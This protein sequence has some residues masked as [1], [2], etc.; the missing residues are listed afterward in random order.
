MTPYAPLGLEQIPLTDEAPWQGDP[1]TPIPDIAALEIH[2][3]LYCYVYQGHIYNTED[4]PYINIIASEDFVACSGFIMRNM[5]SGIDTLAHCWPGVT[6]F[7]LEEVLDRTDATD[8]PHEA[9]AVYGGVSAP[10]GLEWGYANNRWKNINTRAV[11]V[12][13][14]LNWWTAVFNRAAGDL[15]ILRRQ[16]R[17]SMLKFH[18]FNS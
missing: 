7:E 6:E 15:T 13:T 17:Q 11:S 9:I 18:L 16:P 1:N 8:E 10:T 2:P 4:E 12:D 5:K 14:G 3:S